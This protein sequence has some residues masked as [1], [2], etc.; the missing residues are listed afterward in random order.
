MDSLGNR[1]SNEVAGNKTSKSPDIFRL[2]NLVLK[3]LQNSFPP[4]TDEGRASLNERLERLADAKF[5]EV[6]KGRLMSS[7]EERNFKDSYCLKVSRVVWS[8]FSP[9]RSVFET[10]FKNMS[11]ESQ[12]EFLKRDGFEFPR[13]QDK[14]GAEDPSFI[15]GKMA[16]FIADRGSKF[17]LGQSRL[18][19]LPN[20]LLNDN[21]R[22]L[23]CTGCCNLKKIVPQEGLCR[24]L[25]EVDLTNSAVSEVDFRKTKLK[26]IN[27][28]YNTYFT[29]DKK[30]TR[31]D[32]LN[33]LPLDREVKVIGLVNG[34]KNW[35]DGHFVT[36]RD[37]GNGNVGV[38]VHC[39]VEES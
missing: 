29:D 18:K 13:I 34:L 6:S 25:Q 4:Y 21:L 3:T 11:L 9:P 28:T 32:L 37:L 16:K 20:C 36:V 35:P 8:V 27:F 17:D 39:Y 24:N 10:T 38:T 1:I 2:Q 15:L 19:A 22:E 7:A 14:R 33:R 30:E 12:K 31:K 23:D 5:Q 26:K